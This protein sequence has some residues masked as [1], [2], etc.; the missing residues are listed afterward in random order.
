MNSQNGYLKTD[1]TDKFLHRIIYEK[2]Y[3]NFPR[4]Y[5][6]HHIDGKK[7]N[8]GIENL[9]ALPPDLHKEIHRR[10]AL[11]EKFN[12]QSIW[13]IYLSWR[14][15]SVVIDV[16][17]EKK[18]APKVDK[19]FRKVLVSQK[20]KRA[21]GAIKNALLK[22]K[23][24]NYF[25]LSLAAQSRDQGVTSLTPKQIQAILNTAG[26]ETLEELEDQLLK[27]NHANE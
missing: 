27:R 18:P 23:G 26:I 22:F 21:L 16:I 8:N 3:P 4:H 15:A 2:Y 7:L 13:E 12:K 1:V 24:R 9:I 20:N 6:V 11:G 10:M 19:H 14:P 5:E 17:P 25:I